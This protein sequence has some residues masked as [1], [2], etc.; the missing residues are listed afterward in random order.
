MQHMGARPCLC[1]DMSFD[2]F[3]VVCIIKVPYKYQVGLVPY[4]RGVH[5]A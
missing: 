3:P 1:Q 4:G 5:P 2:M